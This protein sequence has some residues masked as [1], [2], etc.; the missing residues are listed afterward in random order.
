MP[1]AVDPRSH[2]SEGDDG[3]HERMSI[4]GKGQGRELVETDETY[5]CKGTGS[6]VP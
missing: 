2:N 6:M 3:N 1:V 5:R 4:Q